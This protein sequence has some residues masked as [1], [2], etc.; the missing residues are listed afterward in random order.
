MPGIR[1]HV[2]PR[3]LVGWLACSVVGGIVF[4]LVSTVHGLLVPNFAWWHQSV[5]ALAL[6]PFGWIQ[7][8]NFFVL[9]SSILCTVP[10]WHRVL[11][12]GI[13]AISYP[14]VTSVLGLSFFATGCL[15]QDPA[16]GYDPAG[17]SLKGP[18]LIGGLHLAAAGVAA[19]SS[20]ALMLVVAAR[21]AQEPHWSG[22]ARYT[23]VLAALTMACVVMY[24]VWSTKPAGLAGTFERMAIL[25]PVLWGFT[26]VRALW[27]GRPFMRAR[28]A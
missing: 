4:L 19:L 1:T 18:T 13:G 9:G 17:L 6:A 14:V 22:W 23:R 20:V 28:E 26:F 5:S 21:L 12:G 11:R 3:R 2:V 7:A 24:G 15:P 10:A 27:A 25:L 8:A 16:P